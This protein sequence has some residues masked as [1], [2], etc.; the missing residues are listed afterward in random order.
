MSVEPSGTRALSAGPPWPGLEGPELL[1][2]RV[3]LPCVGCPLPL[4]QDR[5]GSGEGVEGENSVHIPG[6]DIESFLVQPVKAG[7][8]CQPSRGWWC[9][10]PGNPAAGRGRLAPAPMLAI[11][12]AAPLSRLHVHWGYMP[13]FI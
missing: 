3:P 6:G 13:W 7:A 12:R 10:W 11:P 1:P 9:W 2:S 5:L 8:H 4:Q